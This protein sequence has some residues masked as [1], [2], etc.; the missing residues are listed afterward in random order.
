MW[1][2]F[3]LPPEISFAEATAVLKYR[4]GGGF[5]GRVTLDS[6]LGR[7]VLEQ[8]AQ[9]Y[10]GGCPHRAGGTD[11]RMQTSLVLPHKI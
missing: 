2:K 3:F 9:V 5:G 1:E 11:L 10:M 8:R 4:V 6:N 7:T